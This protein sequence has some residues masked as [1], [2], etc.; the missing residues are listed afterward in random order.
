M[1]TMFIGRFSEQSDFPT[2]CHHNLIADCKLSKV[3]TD[4]FTLYFMG[5]LYGAEASSGDRTAQMAAQLY[6]SEGLQGLK[7]LNGSYTLVIYQ[8]DG[9]V[10]LVRDHHATHAQ[11]YYNK[12]YFSSALDTLLKLPTI[13]AEPNLESLSVFL[14]KGYVPTPHTAINGIFKLP[15]GR[16]LTVQ[17]ET[18][19]VVDQ[20]DTQT[21]HPAPKEDG[22]NL[23]K[24]AKEYR[25]LHHEAIKKCIHGSQNVGIL[26]S[27]GYDSGCNLAALRNVY[28]GIISSYSIGFKGDSWTELPLAKI[29]S[30]QFGTL[31][32]EYEIDGTELKA[33]PQIISHLGDPFVE[34]GLMVN[35]SVM[36]MM[37]ADKP[38]VILGGDGSD[39]YFGTSGREI[40]IRYLLSKSG[41]KGIS[42]MIYKMLSHEVFDKDGLPYRMRFH[43]DKILNLLEGDRFGFPTF[44]LNAL[45]QPDLVDASTP[46]RYNLKSFDHLYTQ[47]AL[48]SDLEQVI[49]QVILFKA[50]RMAEL[51]HQKMAFPY[52]D[53]ELYA[54]LQ[55]LPVEYKC[56]GHHVLDIARGKMTAKFLLK[57]SYQEQLPQAITAKK[58]QG[59]F[60]PMPLFFK[61]PAQRSKSKDFILQSSVCNEFLNRREVERFLTTYDQEVSSS[62][63][64]FWYQQ[65]K[66]IQYFNLL[67]LSIWWEHYIKGHCGITL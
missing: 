50:S 53:N 4:Q 22:V 15:A 67:T 16:I 34:G 23:E 65:N 49:H 63:A 31:H 46:L 26:L 51:F 2:V 61:D 20:Y 48:A 37:G 9:A 42:Q 12:E 27:G 39:Q 62:A 64:W 60:A 38:D 8:N 30:E 11:L 5:R 54:F 24:Y 25:Q 14:S 41:T 6:R 18:I 10:H 17:N 58:K 47:H 3:E 55:R 13:Q 21:V 56:A 52:M 1:T 32:H 7:Q 40:A 29:M 35:Y 36:R 66:A 19:S 33:L 59:G 28:D 44:K 43:L 57:Y 45:I